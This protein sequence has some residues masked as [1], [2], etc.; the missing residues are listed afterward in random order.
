[1][2]ASALLVMQVFVMLKIASFHTVGVLC[3]YCMLLVFTEVLGFLR[4]ATEKIE[5]TCAVYSR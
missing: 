2:S 4:F 1:M 5:I 3:F